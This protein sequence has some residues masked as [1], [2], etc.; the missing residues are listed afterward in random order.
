MGS[1]FG[2]DFQIS[3]NDY[4]VNKR[5]TKIVVRGPNRWEWKHVNESWWAQ[6][7]WKNISV[8]WHKRKKQN[9]WLTELYSRTLS[10]QLIDIIS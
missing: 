5:K 4:C 1:L 2:G 10:I 7:I 9:W 6:I 3:V 8:F